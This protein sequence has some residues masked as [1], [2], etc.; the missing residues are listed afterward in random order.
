VPGHGRERAPQCRD[1]VVGV[2][3]LLPPPR[4]LEVDGR[5]P[6]EAV[7]ADPVGVGV[8][9]REELECLLVA[10]PE[11]HDLGEPLRRRVE[12]LELLAEH[13]AE[14][15]QEVGA[16]FGVGRALELELVEADDAPVVAE[17]AIDFPSRLDRLDVLGAELARALGAAHG[18]LELAEVIDE[19]LAHLRLQLGDASR[20]ARARHGGRLHLEH[21]HVV[22][23]AALL[24]ID[25]LEPRG[26]ADVPRVTIDGVGEVG[27]GADGVAEL[28]DPQLG[29]EVEQ[30][31]CLGPIVDGLRARLVQCDELVVRL[32]LAKRLAQRHERLGVRRVASERG[33]VLTNRGHGG[34]LFPYVGEPKANELEETAPYHASWVE[35]KP[36]RR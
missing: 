25:V 30:L 12:L 26:R 1:G 13:A 32:R 14:A 5:C 11:P 34:N 36:P 4:D 9:A 8:D 22:G 27:L 21:R 28:V 33:L 24:A 2:A 16:P 35:E 20:V 18:A 6:L 31:P 10:G 29:R 7:G 17:R 19:Q 23:H 15:Q 3:R